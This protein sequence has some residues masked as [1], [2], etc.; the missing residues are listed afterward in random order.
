MWLYATVAVD[1]KLVY[2]LQLISILFF[3]VFT[4]KCSMPYKYAKHDSDTQCDTGTYPCGIFVLSASK[5]NCADYNFRIW[6]KSHTIRNEIVQACFVARFP[7]YY[8]L[9]V[10]FHTLYVWRV[11]CDLCRID[12][13]PKHNKTSQYVVWLWCVNNMKGFEVCAV[14]ML[15][16]SIW[17]A[18]DIIVVES[19]VL[20]TPLQLV[21]WQMSPKPFARNLHFYSQASSY[22]SLSLLSAPV[23]QTHTHK[24]TKYTMQNHFIWF[25]K[26]LKV[27]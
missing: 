3:M 26:G 24:H 4:W 25:A 27:K 1:R 16:L 2:S 19:S 23:Y 22:S 18:I 9:S 7:L 8:S 20:G 15:S 12:S 17:Y 21:L 11:A 10:S 5:R 13:R 14:S 6:F